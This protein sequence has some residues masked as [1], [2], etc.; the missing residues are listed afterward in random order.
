[1]NVTRFDSEANQPWFTNVLQTVE[2]DVYVITGHVHIRDIKSNH[3]PNEDWAKIVSAIR[4]VK[5]TSTY[6]LLLP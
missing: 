1:V 4:A 3:I 6:P 5:P 2:A